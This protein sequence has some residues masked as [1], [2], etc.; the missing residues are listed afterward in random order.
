M[1]RIMF[2]LF[3]NV[4]GT[5]LWITSMWLVIIGCLMVPVAFVAAVFYM[6]GHFSH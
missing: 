6:I 5:E 2:A 1:R 4:D 3:P